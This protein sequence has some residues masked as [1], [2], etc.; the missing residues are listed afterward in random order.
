M[1]KIFNCLIVLALGLALSGCSSNTAQPQDTVDQFIEYAIDFNFADMYGLIENGDAMALDQVDEMLYPTDEEDDYAQYFI[2]YLK[3]NAQKIQYEVV[4]SEVDGE[5][6]VVTVECTY[7]DGGTVLVKTMQQYFIQALSQA[8]SGVELTDE[9]YSQMFIDIMDE[10][11]ATYQENTLSATVVFELV[12]IDG[13]WYISDVSD[14]IADVILSGF[15]TGAS[16][17]EDTFSE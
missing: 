2:D 4:S 15:I 13:T 6:A 1:K 17:L 7:V 10:Q 9:E 12:N 3:D 11:I 8:F 16:Q 5:N 14:E